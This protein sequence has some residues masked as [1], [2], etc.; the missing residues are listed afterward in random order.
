MHNLYNSFE[1]GENMELEKTNLMNTLFEFYGSLLTK[2]QQQYVH[3]YYAEDYSLGEIAQ[4]FDV[5]RQAVYDNIKRTEGLL[6][7][8]EQKL[9]I[10]NHFEK[11]KQLIDE[12]EAYI[13]TEY[14]NDDHLKKLINNI[15]KDRESTRGL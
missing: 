7:N 15:E 1:Q 12:L 9:A 3:L 6:K 10:V 8:Y 2:K 4:E 13:N 14:P 11:R 5:S